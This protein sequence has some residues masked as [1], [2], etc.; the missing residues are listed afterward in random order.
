MKKHKKNKKRMKALKS[1]KSYANT[2]SIS[3]ASLQ[4]NVTESL[5]SSTGGSSDLPI[6]DTIIDDIHTQQIPPPPPPNINNIHIPPIL[7]MDMP[8][9]STKKPKG[10]CSTCTQYAIQLSKL[11]KELHSFKISLG[12]TQM[13]LNNTMQ[14]LSHYKGKYTQQQQI[15]QEP[16]R[17]NGI[18]NI[19][20][21]LEYEKKAYEL[22]QLQSQIANLIGGTNTNMQSN[23]LSN[24]P[25]NIQLNIGPTSNNPHKEEISEN[26]ITRPR[27]NSQN[28]MSFQSSEFSVNAISDKMSISAN[29]SLNRYNFMTADSVILDFHQ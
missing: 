1:I 22:K 24:I 10:Y 23:M 27:H 15:Q 29:S 14:E 18:N 11:T 8:I 7:N 6:M 3:S 5:C 9:I 28:S 4:S 12:E 26:T 13:E 25:S 21:K 16:L 20:Y 19:D 2:M 17:N